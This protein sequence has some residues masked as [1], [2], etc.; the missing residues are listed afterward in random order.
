MVAPGLGAVLLA[1]GLSG[2]GGTP[3]VVHATFADTGDLQTRGQVQEADVRIG[4]ISSI[5]LSA[6]F[7]SEVTMHLNHGAKVPRNSEAVLRTTSLLGE[8]FI[9]LRPRVQGPAAPPYLQNGDRLPTS[10]AP[11]LEFVAQ[12]A[13]DVLASVTANDLS[14]I[15][16][17]GA[18]AVGGESQQL[19][20]LI[21][22]LADVSH[23]L[24]TRTADIGRIIDGLDKATATLG[25][26]APDL[27]QLL[28]N[29]QGTTQVLVDNRDRALNALAQ[30][31]RVSNTSDDLLKRYG[32]QLD[33]QIK[34]IDTI[35]KVATNSQAEI[36]NLLHWL[37]QFAIGVP[38][39]SPGEYQYV[40]M[41]VVP[42][43]LDCRSPGPH[44]LGCQR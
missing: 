28:T 9:E 8:K 27:E 16:E 17:T 43:L 40:Y 24:A 35:L 21:S 22:D 7:K 14:T 37:A 30:L 11:E 2:C 5:K 39:N 18:A 31:T 19:G 42:S 20:S 13:V 44:P 15:V 12:V 1:V 32:G 3:V 41:W 26:S 23:T 4:S 36:G 25:T 6:D 10:D 38:K 29:L 33:T 34:Q